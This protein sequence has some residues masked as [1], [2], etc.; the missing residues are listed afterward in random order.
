MF[1]IVCEPKPIIFCLYGLF[2]LLLL[3]SLPC[4]FSRFH[5]IDKVKAVVLGFDPPFPSLAKV[6]I[7]GR[8]D[9]PSKAGKIRVKDQKK[10]KKAK[11]N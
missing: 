9:C 10:D 5:L 3:L 11:E 6:R 7:E 2:L 1:F 4:G 8:F